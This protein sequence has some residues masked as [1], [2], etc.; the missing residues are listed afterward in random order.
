MKDTKKIRK[1]I[2][3]FVKSK[4]IELTQEEN[5]FLSTKIQEHQDAREDNYKTI[6]KKYSFAQEKIGSYLRK[7]KL[8]MKTN[9]A[10]PDSVKYEVK[11]LELVSNWLNSDGE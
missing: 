11:T 9:K 1:E 2:Y 6:V 3:D 4:G 7:G 10:I 8:F 5:S